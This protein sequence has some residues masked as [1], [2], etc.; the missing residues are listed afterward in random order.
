M[1]YLFARKHDGG[2][3]IESAFGNSSVRGSAGMP[4]TGFGVLGYAL[5]SRR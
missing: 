2:D 1:T 3:L 4:F 5:Y